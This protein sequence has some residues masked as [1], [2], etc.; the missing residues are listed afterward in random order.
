MT[1]LIGRIS[2]LIEQTR[3]SVEEH[4][5]LVKLGMSPSAYDQN[6]IV[7][8]FNVIKSGFS[9]MQEQQDCDPAKVT[10]LRHEYNELVRLYNQDPSVQVQDLEL[11]SDSE[12]E[13]ESPNQEPY[14]DEVSPPPQ[15][16]QE[17]QHQR[18]KKTKSVKFKENLV[19][20]PH[21]DASDRFLQ[22]Y[23][24]YPSDEEEDGR[25]QPS[26]THMF[27]QQSLTMRDQD[28]RLSALATS[29]HRQHEL[30]IQIEGELD[31]HLELLDDVDQLTDH[32]QSRL[33]DAKRRLDVFSRKARE[34]GHVTTIV[35]LMF[36]MF[37]L[38]IVL[39]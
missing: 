16:P 38:L 36:I 39:S 12:Q 26:V 4:Q 11:D 18:P 25:D 31:S 2:L 1:A 33:D 17:P 20:G 13:I 3:T 8:G 29:V 19:D 6:E 5:R 21:H 35:L 37:I 22:P 32:S 14:K 7:K 30:S 34:N 24:D 28:S 15:E 27:Q 9:R 10:K 23:H